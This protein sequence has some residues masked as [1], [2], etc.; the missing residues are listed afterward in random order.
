MVS[1]RSH[2]G[3]LSHADVVLATDLRF[4][5]FVLF[6]NKDVALFAESHGEV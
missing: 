2:T 6:T 1:S 3:L 5:L 4:K